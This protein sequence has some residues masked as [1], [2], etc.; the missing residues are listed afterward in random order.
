MGDKRLVGTE[1]MRLLQHGNIVF[2]DEH[3][4]TQCVGLLCPINDQH[5]FRQGRYAAA[6]R[7][8]ITYLLAQCVQTLSIYSSKRSVGGGARQFVA[9]R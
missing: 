4:C 3:A 9:P 1:I 2:I 8:V 6:Q 5:I 7:Q